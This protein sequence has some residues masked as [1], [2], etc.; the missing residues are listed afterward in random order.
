MPRNELSD[1]VLLRP[2]PDQHESRLWELTDRL[3]QRAQSSKVV[4]DR[5]QTRD[6]DEDEVLVCEPQ[7]A[8]HLRA[9]GKLPVRSE[10]HAVVDDSDTA[11]RDA[12]VD[13]QGLP[14]HL[15]D[16]DNA[17]TPLQE[18]A[19]GEDPPATRI[20]RYPAAVFGEQDR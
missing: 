20:V 11:S 5:H 18:Q 3:L 7:F 13:D 2:L 15:P 4:L 17:V 1:G 9:I 19:V 16:A 8:S 10:I 14:H 6:L 12:L